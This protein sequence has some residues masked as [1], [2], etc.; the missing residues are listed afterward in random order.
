MSLFKYFQR[1][2]IAKE[3]SL[4]TACE[5]LK[6][7]PP[8]CITVEEI[9]SV[10]KS[11]QVDKLQNKKSYVFREKEKQE[12]AKF[13][14]AHCHAA[15]IRKFKKMFPT[16]TESTIRPWVK[17]YKESLKEK[18][19]AN[20]EVPLKICQ[21]RGRPMADNA[22]VIG[23]YGKSP[24]MYYDICFKM[25][26]LRINNFLSLS[27]FCAFSFSVSILNNEASFAHGELVLAENIIP[28]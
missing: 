27:S 16:L 23:C 1:K 12:I 24:N 11:L 5:S 9:E 7:N 28:V 18:R 2:E 25:L 19:K 14:S 21:T 4:T 22:I 26:Q 17:R 3:E 20:K 6:E 15:A 13:A 8:E 10:Q